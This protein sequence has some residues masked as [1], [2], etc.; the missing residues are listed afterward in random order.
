M[1]L[2]KTVYFSAKTKIAGSGPPKGGVPGRERAAFPPRQRMGW[3][4]AWTRRAEQA[5]ARTERSAST[6][7][8]LE[9][10]IVC[11]DYI[12]IQRYF[13]MNTGRRAPRRRPEEESPA[14]LKHRNTRHARFRLQC[15]I[16]TNF[17][18]GTFV[19]LTHGDADQIGEWEAKHRAGL[20][21][22]ALQRAMKRRDG[23]LRYIVI[24]ECQRGRWHHH[25]ITNETSLDAVA[26]L[27]KHGRV[28]SSHLDP[29]QQYADLAAYLVKEEK[30]PKGQP[31]GENVKTAR[32]KHSRRLWISGNLTRDFSRN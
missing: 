9:K 21:I 11:G 3:Q 31:D 23:E 22:R 20:Y 12:H 24:H 30:P 25:L 28:T 19:T 18:E 2:V 8:Y 13:A 17:P 27:W 26:A 10:R 16:Q 1:N 32:R 7:P 4:A 15:L 14:D 5:G 29:S 6:M